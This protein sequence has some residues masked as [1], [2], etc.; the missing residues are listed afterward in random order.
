M[1]AVHIAR[2]DLKAALRREDLKR[3]TPD[4]TELQLNPI[5]RVS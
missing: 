2:N 3:L 5:V 1:I 4:G